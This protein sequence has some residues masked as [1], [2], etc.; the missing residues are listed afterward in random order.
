MGKCDADSFEIAS[1][2]RNFAISNPFEKKK[3]PSH[4]SALAAK[5]AKSAVCALGRSAAPTGAEMRC[6]LICGVRSLQIWSAAHQHPESKP[7]TLSIGLPS[8]PPTTP[9][10][11]SA[12]LMRALAPS[13][14]AVELASIRY[15]VSKQQPATLRSTGKPPAGQPTKRSDA[16]ETATES[17][18]GLGYGN[19]GRRSSFA[20]CSF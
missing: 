13:A 17:R 14:V 2:W 18:Q 1:N 12:R 15:E 4:R 8:P 9:Y 10:S 19:N 3:V 7:A 5:R 20:I 11:G 16:C 6:N